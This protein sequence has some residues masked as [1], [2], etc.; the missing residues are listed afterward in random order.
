MG[1]LVQTILEAKG[2]EAP[3]LEAKGGEAP[4]LEAKGGEAPPMLYEFVASFQMLAGHFPGLFNA[5]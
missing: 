2:G 4:I 1:L 3:I 5:T